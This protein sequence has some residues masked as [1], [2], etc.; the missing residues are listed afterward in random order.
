M[1]D[2]LISNECASYNPIERALIESHEELIARIS[3]RKTEAWSHERAVAEI[4]RELDI[5]SRYLTL[6]NDALKT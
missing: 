6:I 1:E 2:G 3:S 4:N 5:L